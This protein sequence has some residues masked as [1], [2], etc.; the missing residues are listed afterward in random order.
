MQQQPALVAYLQVE[1]QFDFEGFKQFLSK[2]LPHY[3]MPSLYEIV[4]SF[5]LLT[6]GKVN[7]KQL[8]TPKQKVHTSN[9]LAPKT[10]LEKKIATIWKEALKCPSVSVNS[11][12]FQ[13]LGGHSLLAAKIV[14]ASRHYPEMATMSLIDLYENPT[15]KQL[16]R[17]FYKINKNKDEHS[18]A[19][20]PNH[21]A[22]ESDA[23]LSTRYRLC[24]LMQV[25][26]T[27]FLQGLKSWQIL[28]FVL[29]FTY[30][31]DKHLLLSLE[32]IEFLLCI[33]FVLPLVLLTISIS[34]KWILLGRLKPGNYPLWGWFYVRWWFVSR[35]QET[36]APV[37][38]LVG[39]PLINLYCRLM[40]AKI[41]KNCFLATQFINTF[42]L[43][44]IGDNSS[45]GYDA[46][47]F[48]YVVED[49]FLKLGTITIG[50]NCYVGSRV[51][52]SINTRLQNDVIL[53][54][55][56]MLPPN[57]VIPRGQCYHGS[58]AR[59]E[60]TTLKKYFMSLPTDTES[61]AV[62]NMTYGA[63]HYISL[64]FIAVVYFAALVPGIVLVDYLLIDKGV[65]Y[66][67]FF[68]A[69]VASFLFIVLLCINIF[70]VKKVLLGK[71][72]DGSYK[73]KSMR[74][75]RYWI[76]E[77]LMDTPDL[78]VIAESLVY[79]FYMRSL[80]AKIGKRVEMA[81]LNHLAPD[82]LTAKD[83][84][85]NA[86]AVS[87]GVPRMYFGYATFAPC[88]LGKRSFVGNEAL[89]PPGSELGDNCLL[90]ATSVPPL[91]N[92]AAKPDTAWFGSPAI[93]MPRREIVKGFSEQNTYRPSKSLYIKRSL[94][95]LVR[96][97]LPT[98]FFLIHLI[99]QILL[100]DFLYPAYSLAETII[101]FPVLDFLICLVLVAIGISLKWL[102][103]GRYREGAKPSWS[104]FIWKCDL[105][106]RFQ[107][108]FIS[109]TMLE[110][111]L[112]TPFIA[113]FIRLLGAKIG[114]RV[115]IE[116]T[117]FF[118]FDLIEIGDDVVL[119]AGSIVQ[120]HLY[121]DRIYKMGQIV[122]N[123]N[124]T[125]GDYSILLYNT[126][127]EEN[128]KLGSLSLLMKGETL[129]A[130]TQ[131]EGIPAQV[132][133]VNVRNTLSDVYILLNEPATENTVEAELR[134][135]DRK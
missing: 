19:E 122:V 69:P 5:P 97:I 91:D 96:V 100:V 105:L 39:S 129:P 126:V 130:N 63:L 16:A 42:D 110:P 10:K 104:V 22:L 38:S 79:P 60:K 24:G 25:I 64:L 8:P 119:N 124:C 92:S 27:Y 88:M 128:S 65:I 108:C 15:I 95:E 3:M 131:W 102:L 121:E 83:E 7:R 50:E 57:G 34:A 133:S 14:S 132:S 80:G 87:V 123:N 99:G 86:S 26:G 30:L 118:E 12:F 61:D 59:P 6:S 66:A 53:E 9:Y 51:V 106:Q 114:K 113:F 98:T 77:H 47:L 49:G 28:L 81:E 111:L 43:L 35:I 82:M 103:M 75:L 52:L 36:V 21:A 55:L 115:Y 20:K 23:N 90:G 2:R 67:V 13:H 84:S 4:D 1:E 93:L 101:Y 125:V 45:V 58:P 46:K 70:L 89:L 29:I 107:T 78:S 11:D 56:S 127:M 33:L 134:V 94:I 40:G 17:K 31:L 74:Y 73:I 54:D 44:E 76:V 85:F 68:G 117:E 37:T 135:I 72:T 48:G 116:T 32:D 18:S 109:P 41:G 62:K 112:G 71:M 120:T